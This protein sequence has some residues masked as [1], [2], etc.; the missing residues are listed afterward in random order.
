MASIAI[1]A[2]AA[3]RLHFVYNHW[4]R[5]AGDPVAMLAVWRG[6]LHAPGCVL[7]A[8]VAAP[9]VC[10]LFGLPLRRFLD[11]VAPM[12]GFAIVGGR[13]G[14]FLD[15]CCYGIQ[16]SLP[17]CMRFEGSFGPVHPL[18]LYF[19]TAGLALAAIGLWLHPRRRYPGEVA[20]I[21]FALFS[22]SSFALEFLRAET[23]E[24]PYWGPLPQLAW[25]SLIPSA[26]AVVGLVAAEARRR[27]RHRSDERSGFVPHA[28]GGPVIRCTA[29]EARSDAM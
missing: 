27:R 12:M 23:P 26:A 9:F 19:A 16:C 6:G 18:Q 5:F 22:M 2:V 4:H 10:R 8:L 17:W 3:G 1:A 24:R 7:G 15:G 21:L 20:L 14:C 13:I 28:R 29:A 11:V 25:T